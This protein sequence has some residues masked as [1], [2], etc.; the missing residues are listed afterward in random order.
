MGAVAV[1]VGRGTISSVAPPTCT[2]ELVRPMLAALFAVATIEVLFEP[3]LLAS[4][5]LFD[6]MWG[7]DA[8]ITA[9]PAPDAGAEMS[10]VARNPL[11]MLFD[12]DS[13]FFSVNLFRSK[14]S[15]CSF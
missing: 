4:I 9:D 2:D 6:A 13:A 7:A 12:S 5:V 14:I 11:G 1:I 8:N 3:A 10:A 15:F